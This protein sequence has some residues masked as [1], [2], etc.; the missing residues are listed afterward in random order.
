MNI[1]LLQSSLNSPTSSN[2]Q[3]CRVCGDR[4]SGRHYGVPSCDGCRGFFKRSVRRN[5]IYKCKD[6]GLCVIDVARRNQCQYC[7][8]KKCFQANMRRDAVQHERINSTSKNLQKQGRSSW[9]GEKNCENDLNSPIKASTIPASSHTL[10]KPTL[11]L[12]TPISV[13]QPSLTG[14]SSCSITSSSG[15]TTISSLSSP[16]SSWS[17]WFCP[18]PSIPNPASG[19]ALFDSNSKPLTGIVLYALNWAL[20]IPAFQSLSSGDQQILL[21]ET[22]AELVLLTL[23]QYRS[24]F[25]YETMSLLVQ[26]NCFNLTDTWR[27]KDLIEYIDSLNLDHIE[28]TCLKALLLFRPVLSGLADASQI[29][30]IQDQAQLLLYQHTCTGMMD[31]SPLRFGR[32]LLLLSAIRRMNRHHFSSSMQSALFNFTVQ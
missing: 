23:L 21:D 25:N 3:A 9:K 6:R 13:R 16:S 27:L 31:A 26:Q 12:D 11:A 4:A 1:K 32:L 15:N 24:S 14:N 18:I 2:E 5:L 30:L 28:F 19:L 8:L 7:R 22:L 29:S 10:T 17:H 20:S